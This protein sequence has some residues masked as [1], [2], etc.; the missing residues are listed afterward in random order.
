[1]N[2][3]NPQS[4]FPK[5][6]EHSGAYLKCYF[7]Q[8]GKGGGV[9]IQRRQFKFSFNELNFSLVRV[10]IPARIESLNKSCDRFTHDLNNFSIYFTLT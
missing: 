10:F 3:C 6:S 2:A 1:M 4:V 9:L 7:Y 8:G 5:R